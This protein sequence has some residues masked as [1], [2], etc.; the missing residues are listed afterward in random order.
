MSALKAAIASPRAISPVDLWGN[1][2]L[3]SDAAPSSG[4]ERSTR[5][6]RMMPIREAMT[7]MSLRA[8]NFSTP[9]MAPQIRVH[10]P[11]GQLVS[12]YGLVALGYVRRGKYLPLVEVRIVV[13]ATVVNWRQPIA[14]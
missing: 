13:L 6:M 11:G 3:P 9:I 7:L 10:T 5:E 14:K 1:E 8:V 4:L 12:G 2:P